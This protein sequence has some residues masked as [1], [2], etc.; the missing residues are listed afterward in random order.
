MNICD[1]CLTQATV[2]IKNNHNNTEQHFCESHY[3]EYLKQ[4][5]KERKRNMNIIERIK[6]RIEVIKFRKNR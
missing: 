5:N 1:L 2:T 4:I 3:Y 6:F